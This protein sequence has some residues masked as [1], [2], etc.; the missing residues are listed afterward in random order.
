MVEKYINRK[1]FPRGKAG[2][3]AAKEYTRRVEAAKEENPPFSVGENIQVL[4]TGV[5]QRR[6][7]RKENPEDLWRKL[8]HNDEESS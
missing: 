4:Q 2:S 3:E 8:P 5:E 7:L 1:L 6:Q